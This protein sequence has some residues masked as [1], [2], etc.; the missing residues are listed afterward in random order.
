MAP[1]FEL[2]EKRST[3]RLLRYFLSNPTK[4]IHA[5]QLAKE[6]E[7]H[8]RGLFEGLHALLEAGIVELE[9]IGRAKQYHLRRDNSAVKQLKLLFT[10]D[11]LLSLLENLRDKGVEVYLYGSAARG[12]DTEKSDIDILILGDATRK[13]VVGEIR[14]PE[15]IKPLFLTFVEYAALARKDKAFYERLEK[16]RIRLM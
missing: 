8:R 4:R 7:F 9:E 5:Q 6:T 11:A 3:S 14:K 15:K 1:I 13:R 16:D 2:L 12:E 10:I